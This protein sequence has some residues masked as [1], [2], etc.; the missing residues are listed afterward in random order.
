[1]KELIT[2]EKVKEKIDNAN[3]ILNQCFNM[4]MDIKRAR[5]NLLDSML[6]FQPLLAECLYE[7]MSFYQEL[8]T[9]EKT[10]VKDKKEYS[11]D[12]FKSV[13][14]ENAIFSKI[15]SEVITIG[16]NLGDAFAWFFYRNNR[17]ELD[18]HFRHNKTGLYVSGLGGYGELQFIKN[19]KFIDG[20]FVLYHGITSMLRIGDFS[21]CDIRQ[22]VLGIG[23]IKTKQE[24]EGFVSTV[25]ISSK[26]NI[27]ASK[28][29][30]EGPL[31]ISDSNKD[32]TKEFPKLSQQLKVQ[33]N[34]LKSKDA[35]FSSKYYLDYEYG[36]IK[37]LTPSYP[38]AVNEDS[39]MLLCA[40]WNKYDTLFD[41]LYDN[42]KA[43]SLPI[44]LKN[45]IDKI[46]VQDSIHNKV[47]VNVLDTGMDILRIPVF[48]WHIED[49]TCQNLYFK[50]CS[51]IIGYNISNLIQKFLNIGFTVKG[52]I[53]SR[54]E[55]VLEKVSGDKKMQF[56]NFNSLCR[57]AT[58]NLMRTDAVF[59][60]A[61]EVFNKMESGEIPIN[62]K[63][64]LCIHLH[65]FGE[66]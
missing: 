63:V 49:E 2:K 28:I 43:A 65:N 24:G 25:N 12:A 50:K 45:E 5:N 35:E 42:G 59:S 17:K 66:Q 18:D 46:I 52:E 34:L 22:G 1:M 38:F 39:S 62:S 51:I 60:C 26:V 36:L 11:S 14:K 31:K 20:L 15:V 7:L 8:K 13:M 23:E 64:E 54:K 4:L 48:W 21:L 57:L 53:E 33:D 16:K 44:G 9:E 30:P 10:L 32:I 56:Q 19:T 61:Q 41:I 40:C 55:I 27:D 37:N 58:H 29:Y 6:N 3:M 47:I